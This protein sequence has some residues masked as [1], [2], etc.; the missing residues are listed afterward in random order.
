MLLLADENIHADLVA[1][2][3]GAGHDVLYAAETMR[4]APDPELL[5]LARRERRIVLTDDLDF[6]ELVLP[7]AAFE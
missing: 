5:E 2:L 7:A 1:W 6:G 3:R 4:R